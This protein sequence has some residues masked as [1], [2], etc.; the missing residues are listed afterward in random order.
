[1]QQQQQPKRKVLEFGDAT[2]ITT[3]RAP[4][5]PT[6]LE[7]LILIHGYLDSMLSWSR[8][9]PLLSGSRRIIALTLRGWGDSS[10]DGAFTV[11]AYATDVLAAMD[12]LGIAKA[13]L[14]G[15]SMGTLISTAVATKAPER[16]AGLVLCGAA[17]TMNPE[18]VVDPSDGTTLGAMGP[19]IEGLFPD[20]TPR[21]LST[22][23]VAFLE[24]FQL[25]DLQPW[26]ERGKV[27]PEFAEQVMAETK[28]AA[29]RACR[30]A[31]ADMLAEDHSGQL[32]TITAPVLVLWG[33]ADVVFDVAAQ[34]TLKDKLVGAAVTFREVAEAPHAVI[35]THA[36]ECSD[37]INDWMA[38]ADFRVRS[39]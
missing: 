33:S 16:V 12:A 32:A 10:K 22:D 13:V 28:K 38:T 7:P 19:Y 31:W 24:S 1:M 21:S 8:V 11:D 4:A 27:E 37:T 35:W 18:H 25:D 36:V 26:V 17:A 5:E 20:T 39:K 34:N 23:A 6:L 2:L 15:H 14:G 29:P 30:E 9:V 3:E